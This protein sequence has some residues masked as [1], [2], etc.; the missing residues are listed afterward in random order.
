MS[1]PL[2]ETV[3]QK[4]TRITER[5]ERSRWRA[6]LLVLKAKFAAVDSKVTTFEVEFLP[7]LVIKTGDTVAQVLS[8]RGL[9]RFL[10][11]EVG[12]ALPPGES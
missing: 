2:L 7:Y 5:E 6:L 8:A 1:I 9:G 11:G 12:L 3:R 10:D 4:S